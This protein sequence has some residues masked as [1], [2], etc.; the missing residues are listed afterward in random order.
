L[1]LNTV[2]IS[3]WYIY[4]KWGRVG[5]DIG[6]DKTE[7]Y[8]TLQSAKQSFKQLYFEKT[9]N[10]WSERNNFVKKPKKFHPIEMEYSS[11][12]GD[13]DDV[14]AELIAKAKELRQKRSAIDPR[15]QVCGKCEYYNNCNNDVVLSANK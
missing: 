13:G 15:L 7:K 5:T 1:C 12:F 8:K 3:Q 2:F 6:G 10:R 4:R 11:H 14:T 9:A